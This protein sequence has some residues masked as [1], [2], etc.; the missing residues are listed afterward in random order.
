MTKTTFL[1]L[2]RDAWPESVKQQHSRRTRDCPSL[3]RLVAAVKTGWHPD[4]HEHASEC[5]Y[6]LRL[7]ARVWEDHPP[8]WREVIKY[9]AAPD[10][11]LDRRAMQIYVARG[12]RHQ[13]AIARRFAD[14]VISGSTV[15]GRI[16][17]LLENAAFV[18]VSLP[19]PATAAARAQEEA[20]PFAIRAEV[21]NTDIEVRLWKNEQDE[22]EVTAKGTSRF[23]ACTVH[24]DI[25]GTSASYPCEILLARDDDDSSFGKRVLG[26]FDAIVYRLGVDCMVAAYLASTQGR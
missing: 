12:G 15:L 4:E 14:F 25:V 18:G 10:S 3:P 21:P 20:T 24:V 9:A 19:I 2:L 11:Y 22:M 26:P 17:T 16:G 6:C 8:A 1:T 5:E 13:Y 7:V 23:A